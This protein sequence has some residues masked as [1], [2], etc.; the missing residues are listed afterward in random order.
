MYSSNSLELNIICGPHIRETISAIEIQMIT[1]FR[2]ADVSGLL[3]GDNHNC[4][5]I[6]N[7]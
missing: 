2:S 7:V 6:Y 4:Q 1:A 5:K 3:R